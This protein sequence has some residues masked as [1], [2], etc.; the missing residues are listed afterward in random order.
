MNLIIVLHTHWDREWYFTTSDSL[1]LMDRTFK[2]IIKELEN[3]ENISFCLD[4]QYSIIEEFLEINPSL[5]KRVKKLVE[6]KRLF[7]GPWFT[8]TDTQLINEESIIRNLYY[9]MYKTKQ[10]FGS[11]MEVGYLP[12]TFGFCNQMPEIYSLLDLDKSIFWRG[13]D[14]SDKK[15]Y[16]YWQGLGGSKIKTVN[17]V[18]GYGMAKGFN[19]SKEFI[20]N[21]INPIIKNYKDLGI[22]SNILIPAG[23]DQY[24]IVHDINNIIKDIKSSDKIDCDL[25][26]LNYQDGIDKIFKEEKFETITS[27][28]RE[29]NYSRIHK[30]IGSIRYDVKKTNYEVEQLLINEVEPL[31]VIAK[32]IGININ[33]NLLY[34]AWTLLF[35]GH[36]H[37]GICGCISDDVYLDLIN[38]NKRAKEIALSIKNMILKEI[39]TKANINNGDILLINQTLINKRSHVIDVISESKNI[40]LLDVEDYEIIQTKSYEEKLDAFIETPIGN[41]PSPQ[42]KYY[43]HKIKVICDMEPLNIKVIKY[44]PKEEELDNKVSKDNFIKNSKFEISFENE[45]LNLKYEDKVIKDFINIVDCGNDGDTYDFSPLKDDK[46]IIFNFTNCEVKKY[47]THQEMNL[48]GKVNLPIDLENRITKSKTKESEF[49]L[50]I[51]LEEKSIIKFKLE[52]NNNVLSHRLRVKVKTFNTIKNTISSS[53]YG[54]VKRKVLTE[55]DLKGWEENY[56]EKPISIETFDGFIKSYDNQNNITLFSTYGKEYEAIEDSIYLTVFSTTGEL[57]KADLIN[58][59]G[60]ASGDITK[61]GHIK[62]DTPLAQNLGEVEFEFGLDI[63]DYEFF[64]V[65]NVLK[66]YRE[67]IINYQIQD[68]NKFFYRIDNKIME[69]KKEEINI[70]NYKPLKVKTNGIITS[71][72]IDLDNNTFIRGISNKEQYLKVNDKEL[73]NKT[74]FKNQKIENNKFKLFNYTVEE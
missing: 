20:E 3:F 52:F 5:E 38:R 66:D 56:S 22:N 61:K 39:S 25:E 46:D 62:I 37:D 26:V 74:V 57:G 71:L 29:T 32:Q 60:R 13:I 30:S 15:P 34:K 36:A 40:D 31:M 28:F 55:S 47:K 54:E 43:H 68:L 33:V 65:M 72:G 16:F 48:S 44:I 50:K 73:E 21:I 17:L 14:L 59:P 23:N 69:Y 9:G 41:I 67:D 12:D 7:I 27:E 64:N 35:E 51:Q 1:V 11:V 53:A 63:M 70:N 58:R 24:E 6:E 10:R 42:N 45:K 2:N 4:G 19:S 18:G 8:Q 49:T